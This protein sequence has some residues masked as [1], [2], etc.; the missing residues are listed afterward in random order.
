MSHATAAINPKEFRLGDGDLSK[1][2]E[3][4]FSQNSGSNCAKNLN[5]EKKRQKKIEQNFEQKHGT[6]LNKDLDI[7]SELSIRLDE[8]NKKT[9]PKTAYKEKTKP[10]EPGVGDIAISKTSKPPVTEEKQIEIA[11]RKMFQKLKEDKLKKKQIINKAVKKHVTKAP[12]GQEARPKSSKPKSKL[13][14]KD[15]EINENNEN[16]WE[17]FVNGMV[18]NKKVWVV[19]G[20]KSY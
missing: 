14:K 15:I 18:F 6:K 11:R 20:K 5:K 16:D 12:P 17:N 4:D 19:I 9:R 10:G 2:D 13:D 1:Y 7:K 8:N 3:K